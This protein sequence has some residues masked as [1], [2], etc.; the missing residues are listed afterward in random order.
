D[1]LR[2]RCLLQRINSTEDRGVARIVFILQESLIFV[3]QLNKYHLGWNLIFVVEFES[4]CITSNLADPYSC[5]T[6][7]RYSLDSWVHS[8]HE[9]HPAAALS[10]GCRYSAHELRLR[11]QDGSLNECAAGGGSRVEKEIRLGE[12]GM[13]DIQSF[14]A[15]F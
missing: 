1:Y 7:F 3:D 12:T 8:G 9:C 2:F 4:S 15:I 14:K 10:H 5:P 11:A 13:G 6:P